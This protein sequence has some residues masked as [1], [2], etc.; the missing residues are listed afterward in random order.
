MMN[1]MGPGGPPADFHGAEA[2][3]NYY[4]VMS[5]EME[6]MMNGGPE[7]QG[8]DCDPAEDPNC[9]QG[10]PTGPGEEC[11]SDDPNCQG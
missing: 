2:A 5:W 8:G 10:P 3:M 11:P 1:G 9:E 6:Q 7:G 4:M